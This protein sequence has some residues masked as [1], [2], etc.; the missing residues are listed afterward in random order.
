M[1]KNNKIVLVGI[2]EDA[3]MGRWCSVRTGGYPVTWVLL[4][5]IWWIHDFYFRSDQSTNHQ[6]T[7]LHT[8]AKKYQKI[9]G[10]ISTSHQ[11]ANR[12]AN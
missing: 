5:L 8:Y 4:I 12:P 10:K 9:H 1:S 3:S 7:S 11:I 2:K 6:H